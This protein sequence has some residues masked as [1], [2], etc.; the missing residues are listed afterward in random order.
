MIT[1]QTQKPI[2]DTG[3]TVDSDADAEAKPPVQVDVFA[4]HIGAII[5]QF[6]NITEDVLLNVEDLKHTIGLFHTA[7]PQMIQRRADRRPTHDEL[8]LKTSAVVNQSLRRVFPSRRIRDNRPEQRRQQRLRR[9]R[10]Q[11][12]RRLRLRRRIGQYLGKQWPKKVERRLDSWD[13]M[14]KR[15]VK[16]W[17][18]AYS[19]KELLSLRTYYAFDEERVKI[20]TEIDAEIAR[21]Q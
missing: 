7:I 2:T 5:V 1:R 11:S 10:H 20:L 21:R 17:L 19:K 16:S 9:R 12:G 14:R 15:K 3:I 13:L 6:R 4:R 8:V 18:S